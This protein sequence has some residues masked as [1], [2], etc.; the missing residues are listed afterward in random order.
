MPNINK[1]GIISMAKA[2]RAALGESAL[3]FLM[4]RLVIILISV[5]AMRFP[6]AGQIVPRSCNFDSEC[7][8][9][10]WYHWDSIVYVGLATRGYASLHETVFFPLWPLLVHI[11]GFLFGA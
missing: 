1:E 9:S 11:G 6:L 4:S 7:L 10:L 2:L 8:L 3:P 5:L